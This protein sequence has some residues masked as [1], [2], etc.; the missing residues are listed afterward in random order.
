[1]TVTDRRQRSRAHRSKLDPYEAF[2][3]GLIDAKYDI[4]L[5]GLRDRLRVERVQPRDEHDRA[6]GLGT[7]WS[8]P[9][10]HDLTYQYRQPD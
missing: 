9:Y 1:M 4:T 7:L 2:L 10:A 5:E 6:A 8:F 3:R